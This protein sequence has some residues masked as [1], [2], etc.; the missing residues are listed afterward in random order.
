MAPCLRVSRR[1][2]LRSGALAM[3]LGLLATAFAG[4]VHAEGT[5]DK[6]KRRGQVNVGYRV[7][8][9]PFSY[10]DAQGN[11]VGYSLD[12]CN[13]AV[14]KLR[15]QMGGAELHVKLVPVDMDRVLRFVS[16]GAIDLLCSSTSDTPARRQQMAFSKPIFL[17]GVGVMVRAKDR[18]AGVAELRGKE[19]VAIK[20][21]TA[22]TT[23]Q[24]YGQKQAME[25]KV[26][27]A[28]NADAALSALELGWAAGY[29]RDAVPLAMQRAVL[30]NAQDYVLLPDRLSVET[31][32]IAMPAGDEALRKFINT[33]ITE[34]AAAGKVQA[35][36]ARWFTQPITVGG[37]QATLGIPLSE[38]LKTTFKVSN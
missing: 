1:P 8:A 19:V 2:T 37:K 18:V 33:V 38:E 25:W 24:A 23:L 20:A 4:A 15:S 22:V 11:P 26:E 36:Y 3:A 34:G 14:E 31:I 17:D 35:L 5:L 9:A 21:S 27:P 30:P 6:I 32:A 28:L 16:E 7:D 29:A 13:E 12:I 10:N